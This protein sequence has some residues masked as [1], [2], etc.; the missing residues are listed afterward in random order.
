MFPSILRSQGSTSDDRIRLHRSAHGFSAAPGEALGE[1]P[2][3]VLGEPLG[4]EASGTSS[5]GGCSI[6]GRQSPHALDTA[7]PV[8]TGAGNVRAFRSPVVTR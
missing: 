5:K 2:G 4:S 7:A 3:E 8:G 1:A 6:A